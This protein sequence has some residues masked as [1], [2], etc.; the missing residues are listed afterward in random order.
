MCTGR[1]WGHGELTLL[2]SDLCPGLPCSSWAG[3]GGQSLLGALQEQGQ[4][5]WVFSRSMWTWAAKKQGISCS[6]EEREILQMV[7]SGSLG[8]VPRPFSLKE[9]EKMKGVNRLDWTLLKNLK[10]KGGGRGE[11]VLRQL[12]SASLNFRL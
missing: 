9:Q 10:K 1:C 4:D 11:K 8:Q 2:Q 7:A 3:Q 5:L 6:S 12:L